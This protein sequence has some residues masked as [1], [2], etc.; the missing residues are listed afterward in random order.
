MERNRI[1]IVPAHFVEAIPTVRTLFVEYAA[2]LKIDLCFQGFAEEL[3]QLPGDYTPP[4][5]RLYLARSSDE[6]AGCGALRRW[7]DNIGEMK[8]L[9]VR[10]AFRGQGIGKRLAVQVIADARSI[11]Y[12]TL[13]LD[14]LPIVGTAIELYRALGFKEIAPYRENPVPGALYF[15]LTLTD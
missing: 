5:G 1:Q 15:E 10:E 4:G 9:Y 12:R 2:W 14:T 7:S 8:R 6:V 13:R 11:G 3:K